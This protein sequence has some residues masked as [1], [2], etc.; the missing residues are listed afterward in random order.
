MTGEQTNLLHSKDET[1]G[2][3]IP[4]AILCICCV[5]LI[6][7][8]TIISTIIW[9]DAISDV[10]SFS[11]T[12]FTDWIEEEQN[13]TA[14]P[15]T[16]TEL[17]EQCT[18]NCTCSCTD[19][20]PQIQYECYLIQVYN[21]DTGEYDSIRL[22]ECM[23]TVNA[24]AFSVPSEPFKNGLFLMAVIME[25]CLAIPLTATTIVFIWF[26]LKKSERII[27]PYYYYKSIKKY[28]AIF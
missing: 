20:C 3:N 23:V 5:S 25:I 27:L 14:L 21:Q 9:S 8:L 17:V 6:V 22:K 19:N 2:R 10:P 26:N 12:A 24:L 4:V 28:N 13:C 1:G 11:L 18:D 15:N 7:F 16:V